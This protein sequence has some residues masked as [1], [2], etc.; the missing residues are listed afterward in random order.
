MPHI[1]TITKCDFPKHK[2]KY[3]RSAFHSKMGGRTDANKIFAS[4]YQRPSDFRG[5]SRAA[6]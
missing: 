6:G 5:G 4:Y 3:D 2:R 1:I